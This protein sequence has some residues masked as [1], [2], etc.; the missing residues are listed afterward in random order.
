MLIDVHHHCL[1]P[2][3]VEAFAA[4]RRGPSL[5]AF[6]RW[7]PELSIALLDQF[8]ID[9]AM[10]SM[11]V[12]GPHLGDDAQ[13]AQLARR[14]NDYCAKL[15]TQESRFGAFGTLPMP[16]VAASLGELDHALDELGL[17]GIGLFASYGDRFLGDRLFDPVL[18]ELN[19]RRAIVFI[20]PMGHP[21]SRALNL[22]APLWML[23]YPIDTTRA[24]VAQRTQA[25]SDPPTWPV[26][27]PALMHAMSVGQRSSAAGRVRLDLTAP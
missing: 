18:A 24:A 26:A 27:M 1:P 16:D 2:F 25:G 4:A 22:A 5:P 21:S 11:A 9:R 15:K 17:D 12:P 14:F 13:G 6:P 10:L 7:M 23:E 20:H 3:L 8:A 19:R